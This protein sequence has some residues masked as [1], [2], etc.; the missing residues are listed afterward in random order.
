LLVASLS[1]DIRAVVA[2]VPSGVVS[3]AFG[4]SEFG[5]RRP[6]GAWTL[7]GKPV[8][9][10]WQDNS[11]FAPEQSPIKGTPRVLNAMRDLDAMDRATIPVERIKGPVLMVSGRDDQVWP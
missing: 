11:W 8:P 4:P 10:M 7:G 5:D 6:I 9:G 2:V 3:G 1:A